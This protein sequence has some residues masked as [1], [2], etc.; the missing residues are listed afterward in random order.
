MPATN[1]N[2]FPGIFSEGFRDTLSFTIL[3]TLLESLSSASVALHIPEEIFIL[4]CAV[5]QPYQ[6]YSKCQKLSF[7]LSL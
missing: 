2:I 5:V 6:V 3:F 1:L 7:S 4:L